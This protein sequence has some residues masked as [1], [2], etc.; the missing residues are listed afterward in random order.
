MVDR[1]GRPDRTRRGRLPLM[2][3]LL[4]VLLLLTVALAVIAALGLGSLYAER[5]R[6]ED[7][8]ARSYELE[9]AAARLQAAGVIE[10]S[11]LGARDAARRRTSAAFGT[12]AREALAL[13]EGDGASAKLVRRRVASQRRVRLAAATLRR[14]PSRTGRARVQRA[15]LRARTPGD[16]LA[17]RQRGRRASARE[18][19]RDG[20]RRA[21][22]ITAG[23]GVLGLLGAVGLIFALIGSIRKPLDELVEATL[24]LAAGQRAVRVAPSGPREL[25]ELNDSFN[26]MA[27]RLERAQDRIESER[28][29]LAITVESLRDGLVVCDA[30][31]TV[32]SANPRA[33]EIV[34]GLVP[35]ADAESVDSPLPP[36]EEALAEEVEVE[37]G[38]GVLSITAASLDRRRERGTVWTLRDVSERARVDR[39]KSDFVATASHELR[40]PLTSIKGFVELLGR[41]EALDGREREFVDV[42]LGS[43]DRLVDLVNDLLDVA[44][45]DAGRMEVHPRLF[46]LTEVVRDVATL[47]RPR[48]VEK[49]QRLDLDLPPGLPRAL[50]DPARVRQVLINLVSNA[51]Q[52]TPAGGR[53]EL[54]LDAVAG[55]LELAVTDDGRGMTQDDLDHVFDRFVRRADGGGGTGLGLSIVRSLMDLQQGSVDVRS[56]L[57]EGTT[58][59]VRLPTEPGGAREAPSAAMRGRRVL[60]AGDGE[61]DGE[62]LVRTLAV[63]EIQAERSARGETLAR[64]RD[65][66]FDALVVEAGDR[67]GGGFALLRE[68]RADPVLRRTAVVVIVGSVRDEEAL[69]GEWRISAPADPE[70]LADTLGAALLAGRTS[71]LVAGRSTVRARLEPALVRLG[72]DHEWVTSGAAAAQACEGR[73][74]EVALVDAG[75][76]DPEAVLHALDLRGRR[77]GHA[78]LAF[79][80]D[81][82]DAP[83]RAIAAKTVPIDEAAAAVLRTLSQAGRPGRAAAS[84]RL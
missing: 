9:A 25:R 15:V 71:V 22:L 74:F 78:V 44:R 65:E 19:A 43:T 79:T 62:A 10:E 23:A 82:T 24:A 46:D 63:H 12:R 53:I 7:E 6:Y 40:S 76:R 70:R 21:L 75:I 4:L 57:G 2:R 31:G 81:E 47:M 58:F 55:E 60:I 34:P 49:D 77:T 33:A 80:T 18:A 28:E 54:S 83:A 56:R 13:A 16:A 64:L 52:Y 73:R 8:L 3:S 66:G 36:L 39:M 14:S 48:A 61:T 35:G 67:D 50:A 59:T 11:T 72:L 42:I 30:Q 38:G 41:S 51:H 69:F 20:T 68:L 27:E 5:Q 17:R 26:S 84:T 29:K 32:T 37:W 45:L 1:L